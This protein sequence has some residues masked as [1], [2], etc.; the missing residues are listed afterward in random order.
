MKDPQSQQRKVFFD[1]T[2][3]VPQSWKIYTN[4]IG[5]IGDI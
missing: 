1:K 2:E 4:L 3:F 5:E